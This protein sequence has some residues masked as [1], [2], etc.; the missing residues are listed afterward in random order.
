M[1][2]A[3]KAL[4]RKAGLDPENPPKTCSRQQEAAGKLA[5]AGSNCLFTTSAA[6]TGVH[7][8]VSAWN[9]AEVNDAKGNWPSMA[10]AQ[11][12]NIAMMATWYKSK[13][14]SYFGPKDEADK[15][16]RQR[17][18]RHVDQFF[19]AVRLFNENKS[20]TLAFRPAFIT[21][22]FGR[23]EEHAGRRLPRCGSPRMKPA[24]IK[25]AAKF[26]NYVLGP[27]FR[28]A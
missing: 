7:D 18:V 26:R 3:N 28:S 23:T 8:N 4:F 25:G 17:R 16:V 20:L 21:T 27:R 9:G 13:Y 12:G 5:D 1:F 10:Q 6:G 11:A 2:Y 15:P 22:M 24:E 14:F 19:V